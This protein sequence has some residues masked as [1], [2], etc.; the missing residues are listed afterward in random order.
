MSQLHDS[1]RIEADLAQRLARR[2]APANF[3][4][5]V[6][7]AIRDGKAD[8]LDNVVEFRPR[9][10]LKILSALAAAATLIIGFGVQRQI[11]LNEAAQ[12]AEAEVAEADLIESLELAGLTFNRA[13]DAAFGVSTLD[14][15]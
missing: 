2:P 4:D 15:R 10:K 13:R 12:L 11:Q 6:M 9:L 7:A 1:D 3:A 5:G 8:R 14:V